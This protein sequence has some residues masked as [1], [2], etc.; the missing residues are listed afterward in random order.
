MRT[1]KDDKTGWRAKVRPLLIG[2]LSAVFSGMACL[3]LVAMLMTFA[4][5]PSFAVTALAVASAAVGAFV[6]G[7]FS[8]KSSGEQ[9]WFMGLLCGLSLFLPITVVGFFLHRDV[10]MGFLF[11]KLFTLLLSGMAGGVVGV[12]KR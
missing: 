3:L 2:I 1:R 4:D 10:H 9:G 7:L 8:A 12:N 6:G 11:V 5:L